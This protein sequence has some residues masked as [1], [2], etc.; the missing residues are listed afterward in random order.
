[1]LC[2]NFRFTPLLQSCNVPALNRID[3]GAM[4]LSGLCVAHCLALPLVVTL[5]PLGALHGLDDTRFHWVMLLFALPLS[6]FGLAHGFH[7]H[8]RMLLPIIGGVGL[9]LMA[10]DLMPAVS[11]AHGHP[12][13]LPGVLLVALAHGLNIRE[14]RRGARDS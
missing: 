1:L 11:G 6:L 14:I 2:Y 4:A 10:W 8:R 9:L 13:T 7:R 5:I 3:I 12:L